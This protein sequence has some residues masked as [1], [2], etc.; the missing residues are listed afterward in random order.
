MPS[1]SSRVALPQS[2][3]ASSLLLPFRTLLVVAAVILAAAALPTQ[4][5]AA[6][7]TAPV[8]VVV[9]PIRGSSSFGENNRKLVGVGATTTKKAKAT[10]NPSPSRL[11]AGLP[12]QITQDDVAVIEGSR[13]AFYFWFFGSSGGGG[14]GLGAFPR[15]FA[16]FSE[17]MRMKDE[18]PTAAALARADEG[19]ET[20]G[21]NPLLCLYPR[22]L[23]AADVRAVLEANPSVEKVVDDNPVEGNFLSSGG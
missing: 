11:F 18:G 1:L 16:T 3:A 9:D 17:T 20:L 19:T 7:T 22:D 8:V 2:P 23:Y 12:Q 13:Q 6:F 15:M 21:M 5:A 10:P 4:Q 14:L